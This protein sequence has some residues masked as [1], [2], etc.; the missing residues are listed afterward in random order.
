LTNPKHKHKENHAKI[1]IKLLKMG[2][3]N[4]ESSQRKKTHTGKM[5]KMIIVTDFSLEATP[6]KKIEE[7]HL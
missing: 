2:E 4:H 7:K 6:A 5:T 3:K 1:I